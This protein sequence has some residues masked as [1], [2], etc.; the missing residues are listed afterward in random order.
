MSMAGIIDSQSSASGQESSASRYNNLCREAI[1]YAQEGAASA[2]VYNVAMQALRE[3]VKKVTGM[4]KNIGEVANDGAS[5]ESLV[6]S[7]T[8]HTVQHHK[9]RLCD[10]NRQLK[11]PKSRICDVCHQPSDHTSCN[12]PMNQLVMSPPG[13]ISALAIDHIGTGPS[14]HINVD[15]CEQIIMDSVEP[16]SQS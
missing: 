11:L 5:D 16:I 6:S 2:D 13:P 10:S 7:S 4:K 9:L 1:K 15:P 8:S 14:E 12:C 3:A